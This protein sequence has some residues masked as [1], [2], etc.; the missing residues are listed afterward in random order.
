MTRSTLRWV[1]PSLLSAALLAPAA[2]AYACVA[3]MAIKTDVSTVEPGGTV[4]VFG[5][6]FASDEPVELRLD[7]LDGPLLATIPPPESTMT[8]KFNVPVTIPADVEPGEHVI[9]ANQ[10]YHHMNSGAPAR[11]AIF[12]GTEAP[13]AAVP[14]VRAASVEMGPGSSWPVL[15]LVGLAVAAAALL[16]AALVNR[17]SPAERRSDGPPPA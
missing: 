1:I 2:I 12:V 13:A 17:R 10:V 9:L 8:S 16:L 7:S 11:A 5:A 4:N 14:A 15:L 6:D 3:V